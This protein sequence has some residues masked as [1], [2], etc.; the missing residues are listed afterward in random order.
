[1]SIKASREILAKNTSLLESRESLKAVTAITG[2]EVQM[3]AVHSAGSRF[4]S[5]LGATAPGVSSEPRVA[6]NVSPG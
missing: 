2:A 1:M 3:R 5:L 6:R 4:L